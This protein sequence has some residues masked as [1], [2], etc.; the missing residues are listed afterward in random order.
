VNTKSLFSPFRKLFLLPLLML[1]PLLYACSGDETE[2]VDTDP[3]E[4]QEEPDP[5]KPDD[6]QEEDPGSEDP[7]DPGQEEP[8]EDDPGI[9]APDLPTPGTGLRTMHIFTPGGK[10]I[11]SKDYWTE[12]CTVWLIDDEGKG[13]YGSEEVS[14][15]GRGN[16]TWW[17]FPKK[18]YALKLPEKADLIGTGEDK[19][20]VLLANWMDRTLLRN[21]VAFEAARRT[22]LEWTPSGE[23]IE[24][25]LNGV[26]LGNYWL[27]EKI[28]TGKSRLTA[29]YIIEMDTYYD[30]TWRFYSKYGKRVNENRT[31]MPIGVKEPDDDKM[32][33]EKF[34]QLKKMVQE[35]EEAIYLG[36]ADYRTKIDLNSFIDWY[37]VHELTYNLEPNHPKSCYFHFRD[38]VMYAGPVWDFDWYTFQPDKQ[39]LSLRRC[40][41]YGQLFTDAGFVQALK[42]RWYTL[43]FEFL[44]LN[45]YIDEKAAQIRASESINWSMWPCTSFDTN[46]DVYLS[47]DEAVARMKRAVTQRISSL[48]KTITAL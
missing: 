8:G 24:L 14:I 38:G 29:D 32:T 19:R 37:L 43:K 27:G 34:D 31:G 1:V 47:F 48:D 11:E 6:P 44:T 5:Q 41:Y 13:Y 3:I 40:I 39:G 12:N 30:A 33:Q 10:D 42:E 15:K 23:F 26:H 9:E 45:D 7:G 18:P 36:N 46:E 21:D 22:S 17:S 25:Y 20:W 4:H 35:A 2:P 16:S 28:K